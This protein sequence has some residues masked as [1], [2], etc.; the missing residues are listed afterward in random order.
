DQWLIPHDPFAGD[1]L[2]RQFDVNIVNLGDSP[3]SGRVSIGLR[4]ETF[5]LTKAGDSQRVVYAV[6][7]E[8]GGTDVTP[9]TGQSSRRI[10]AQPIHLDAGERTLA[11]FTFAGDTEAMLGQGVY[12]QTAFISVQDAEGLT[13]AEHP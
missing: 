7:D 11:R 9:R 5:G 4:G 10:N 1:S 12:S 2:Q 3:C 13:L 8:R 6:V